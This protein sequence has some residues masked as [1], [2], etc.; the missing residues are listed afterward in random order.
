VLLVGGVAF[1]GLGLAARYRWGTEELLLVPSTT[2]MM[3]YLAGAAA[4]IR[5]L[6]GAGRICA[7]LTLVLT[8]CVLPAAASGALVPVAIAAVALGYRAAAARWASTRT[9]RP[10]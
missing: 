7:V 1:G 3:V 2:V 9:G 5:L 6:T 10:R 8:A 4:G